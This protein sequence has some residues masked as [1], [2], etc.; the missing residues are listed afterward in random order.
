MILGGDEIVCRRPN[1]TLNGQNWQ[2]DSAH[3]VKCVNAFPDLVMA[4]EKCAA[5]F[6]TQPGSVY[7]CQ[8]EISAEFQRR[9]DVAGRALAAAKGAPDHG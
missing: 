1:H 3:I 2:T 9:M 6:S 4:L 5:P 7:Q 8:A